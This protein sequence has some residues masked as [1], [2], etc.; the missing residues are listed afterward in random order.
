MAPA[1]GIEALN[2]L[3]SARLVATA[4]LERDESR[5]PHLRFAAEDALAPVPQDDARW[6][7]YIV[8]RRGERGPIFEVREPV[9]P[10][11]GA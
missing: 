8:L 4:A 11:G 7:R 6:E 3:Q 5:G 9:R 10:E 1:R 2:A